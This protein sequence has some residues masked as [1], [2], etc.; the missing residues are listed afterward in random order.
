MNAD[1]SWDQTMRSIITDP[2]YKALNTLAEK[3]EAWQKVSF[4]SLP[5]WTTKEGLMILS[6]RKDCDKKKRKREKQGYPNCALQS[7]ICS[8]AILTSSTI[9]HL[10]QR[11]S[12]FP[13]TL[14]GSRQRLK[15]NE[16]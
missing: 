15:E 14:F 12:S 10:Q 7:R 9:L 2:L 6:T 16:N 11:T 4:L 1:W 13:S 3:K 8:G 5:D